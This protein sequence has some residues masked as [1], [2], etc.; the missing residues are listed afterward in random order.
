MGQASTS[1]AAPGVR[2][3]GV[4]S[5]DYTGLDGRV[6]VTL[7]TNFDPQGVI[8]LM[9]AIGVPFGAPVTD[10]TASVTPPNQITFSSFTNANPHVLAPGALW[11]AVFDLPL[12][13][14][15]QIGP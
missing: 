10:L 15:R 6:L 3:L 7:D 14:V 13:Q 1:Q 2:A 5:A 9:G 8:V 4:V 11:F 12:A